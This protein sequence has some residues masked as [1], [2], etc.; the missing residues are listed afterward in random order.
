M[1]ELGF[2]FAVIHRRSLCFFMAV[3]TL[4]HL[5][6]LLLFDIPFSENVLAYG[7][8]VRYT[9]VPAFRFLRRP[10][11]LSAP[12]RRTAGL[13]LVAA[14]AVGLAATLRGTATSDA[15]HLP[16]QDV[17]MWAGAAAGVWYLARVL[18]GRAPW[19]KRKDGQPD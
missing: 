1:L 3:A 12:S 10:G 2:L 9:E 18:R 16:L 8:F 6:V 19:V 17:A 11:A 5:G 7:P 13:T 15:L 14:I 4:F